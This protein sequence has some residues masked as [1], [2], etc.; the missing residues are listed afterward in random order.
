M[1]LSKRYKASDMESGKDASVLESRTVRARSNKCQPL[2]KER[3]N[4]ASSSPI[5]HFITS[6]NLES[7]QRK[8][9]KIKRFDNELSEGDKRLKRAKKFGSRRW[10]YSSV[11]REKLD[12][13]ADSHSDTEGVKS[14]VE[15]KESLSDEVAE[16]ETKLKLVM[17]GVDK[18][19]RQVSGEEARTNFSKTLGTGISTQ[20]NPVKPSKVS[21]KYLKKRILKALPASGTTGSGE[22][23]KDK[24]GRVEPSGESEVKVA[25]GR[26]ALVGDLKE[27]KE[28]ARLAVLQGEEDTSKMLGIE[29]MKSELKKVNVELEKELARSRA[30]TLK[31]VKQLK[32][33]H[34]VAIGQLQVE[35]KA[36]LD[37]MVEER[38]RLGHHL[39]LK[40]NSEEEVDAIEADTYVEEEDEEEAEAVGIVDSLYGV[41]RQTVLDNQGDNVDLPEGGSEKVVREMSLRINDLEPGLARERKTFKALLSAQAELQVE[42]KD[43]EINKGLKELAE[44][45]ERTEKLQRQVDALAVAGKQADTA[46]YHIQALEQSEEQFRSDLHN[47]R[48]ELERMRRKF[49]DKDDELRV[50]VHKGNANLRECQHKLD[51]AL[52]RDK[53]L[54]GEIKAKESLVKRKKDLLKDMPVREELNAEIG[55]LHARAVDLEAMSLAESAK[56]IAKLEENVIYHDKVDAEMTEL[57]N[58][59]ARL[60]SR[61]ERLRVRFAIM[62]IHDA[63]RSDLLKAIITYFMEEVKRLEL[64]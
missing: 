7:T 24:R 43:V 63:S 35:T 17:V 19:K 59:Y 47:Y 46:Q 52:I 14:I 31:E 20:P 58:D 49:V 41:S 45:T 54:E 40:S 23:V 16:E 64:E 4:S 56:Y 22:V 61:L 13:T 5:K 27:V 25:E 26:S 36:N 12:A 51:A 30:D 28:R 11:V 1:V 57:K 62:V 53:V 48:N 60:E 39:M 10:L 3:I 50:H 18:G 55:R 37:E 15:M 38:D 6:Q 33:S 9:Q 32:A 34:A 8:R 2:E 21:L 29:G 42:E 44:V